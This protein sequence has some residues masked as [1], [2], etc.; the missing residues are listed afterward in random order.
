MQQQESL[1]PRALDAADLPAV[2]RILSTSDFVHYR[3]EPE[4]LQ[5]LLETCPAVGCFSGPTSRLGRGMHKTLRAFL[6]TNWIAPPNAWIGG[7]GVNWNQGDHFARFLDPLLREVEPLLSARGVRMLY[8]SG[9]DLN[10]D[11]LRQSLEARAFQLVSLLRSYDKTDFTVP[12][13]GNR[14]VVVRPFILQDL[15]ALLGIEQLAFPLVWRHDAASFSGIART[16]PYFVVAELGGQ[17]VGYQFN[18]LDVVTGYLVRI[19]VH[20]RVE[21]Q[22][23]GTRLMAE[24]VHYF[25]RRHVLRIALNT[26]EDNVRAHALYE[27]FGFERVAPRGFV[28]GRALA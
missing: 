3:F 8:Y 14:Q 6:L 10:S 26:E 4:E 18:T 19:A 16:Y 24:A 17:V 9:G 11:W 2:R 22:G 21:G 23:V 20:P 15:P 1:T 5:R 12:A 13:A 25:E 7:F 27:W 28:L